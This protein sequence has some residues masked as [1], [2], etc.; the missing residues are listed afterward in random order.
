MSVDKANSLRLIRHLRVGER[1]KFF[2]PGRLG[3]DLAETNY[4]C[5]DVFLNTLRVGKIDRTIRVLTYT[6]VFE[7]MDSFGLFATFSFHRIHKDIDHDDIKCLCSTAHELRIDVGGGKTLVVE[8]IF[9][10]IPYFVRPF[11]SVITETSTDKASTDEASTAS[12]D[13]KRKSP[14]SLD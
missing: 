4:L 6:I 2:V 9:S 14:V 12:N 1:E 7:T 10:P 11:F 8:T 5:G 13:K 3:L